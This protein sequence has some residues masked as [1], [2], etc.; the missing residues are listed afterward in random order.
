[1]QDV[2]DYDVFI[3]FAKEDIDFVRPIWQE[4]S[5]NGLR[6]FWST[7][8]LKEDS[9]SG[10]REVI[11]TSL[12]N[13]KHF[14][15]VCSNNSMTSKWVKMEY[16]AFQDLY[17]QPGSRRLIPLL[18]RGFEINAL[19]PFL[20]GLQ[21]TNLENENSIQNITKILGGINFE[22]LKNENKKLKQE[23]VRLQAEVKKL[24]LQKQKLEEQLRSSNARHEQGRSTNVSKPV[25]PGSEGDSSNFDIGK[26][27]QTFLDKFRSPMSVE[28]MQKKYQKIFDS[29]PAGG[30]LIFVSGSPE[31]IIFHVYRG[32]GSFHGHHHDLNL[33][34]ELS[35]DESQA[36][37][38]LLQQ[39]QYIELLEKISEEKSSKLHLKIRITSKSGE[40]ST[41][42]VTFSHKVALVGVVR[43]SGLDVNTQLDI[44][45]VEKILL[46]W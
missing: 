29:T 12:E 6:V 38:I 4:L 13:S 24:N 41:W 25:A 39:L 37:K 2:F 36:G 10:W 23:N 45:R 44:D 46:K 17:Y 42:Y 8:S 16:Q 34:K 19:P 1:M 3:S 33:R 18:M 32:F 28:D 20:R 5:T 11:E 14:L 22:E 21:A 7:E 40:T 31:P 26:R 35:G 30:A 27:R 9:G 43:E 15:L